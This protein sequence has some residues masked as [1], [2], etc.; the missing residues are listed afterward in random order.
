MAFARRYTLATVSL[1][2]LVVAGL[3]LPVRA[4][5][6]PLQLK[7]GER[8]LV[9]APHPDDETLSAG[10]LIQRVLATGGSVRIVLFTAGDGYVEAV[11]HE[12]GSL[13]PRPTEYIAY[14]ERR[15][16]EARAAARVLGNGRIRLQVLGFPDGGL[17]P[18]LQAH[19][20]R[21]RPERSQTTKAHDPPYDEALEP[22]V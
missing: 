3:V 9:V 7:N 5:V 22:D 11:V 4:E 14:G 21:T 18:L 19:W 13:R 10:G 8:L 6:R 2:S 16:K 17:E 1:M 15:L 20:W 12:T